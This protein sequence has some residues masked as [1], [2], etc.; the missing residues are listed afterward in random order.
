MK[1]GDCW[2]GLGQR[3]WCNPPDFGGESFIQKQPSRVN[4]VGSVQSRTNSVYGCAYQIPAGK[5]RVFVTL[6]GSSNLGILGMA[7]L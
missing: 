3:R 7:M 6:P 5:T 2:C 1:A 4:Q